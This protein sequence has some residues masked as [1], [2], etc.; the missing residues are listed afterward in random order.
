[1]CLRYFALLPYMAL[2]SNI[3]K[4]YCI[5][6]KSDRPLKSGSVTVLADL[7]LK[8][9]PRQLKA[10]LILLY[11]FNWQISYRAHYFC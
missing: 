5:C 10:Q 2:D 6:I 8:A 4:I 1:M 3:K 9:T 7:D 11:T